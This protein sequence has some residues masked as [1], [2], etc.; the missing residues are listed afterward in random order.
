VARSGRGLFEIKTQ[1]FF[2]GLREITKHLKQG[3]SICLVEIRQSSIINR[4]PE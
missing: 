4:Q 1:H 3:L 2:W